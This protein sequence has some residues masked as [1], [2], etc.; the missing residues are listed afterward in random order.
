M[1]QIIAR[2]DGYQDNDFFG[3]MAEINA[4]LGF[5]ELTLIPAYRRTDL[6]FRGSPRAFSSTLLSCPISSSEARLRANRPPRL[7]PRH[8]LFRGGRER[9]QF[10][11][12]ASTG[13]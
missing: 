6:D 2:D 13:R 8:L 5:A 4:D 10:F 11:D 1:P 9:H 12:Q 7:G 3:V